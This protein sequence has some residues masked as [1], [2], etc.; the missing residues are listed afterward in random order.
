VN[1]RLCRIRLDALGGAG[2]L[3]RRGVFQIGH[4][5]MR[6]WQLVGVA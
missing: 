5:A 2:E 6:D 1:G 4:H 3:R